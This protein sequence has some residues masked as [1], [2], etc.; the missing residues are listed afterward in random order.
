MSLDTPL[1][2]ATAM[3]DADLRGFPETLH[4]HLQSAADFDRARFVELV[5]ALEHVDPVEQYYRHHDG[6]LDVEQVR[7][8]AQ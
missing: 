3:V 5:G 4:T 1:S 8:G 7:G 2:R 6:D